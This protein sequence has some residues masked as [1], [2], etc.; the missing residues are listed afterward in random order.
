[1]PK[2]RERVF[3]TPDRRGAASA[4]AEGIA[5]QI[6]IAATHQGVPTLYEPDRSI[7]KVVGFPAVRGR[8]IRAEQGHGNRAIVRTILASVER[9]QGLDQA[10][11]PLRRQLAEVRTR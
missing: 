5:Q 7:A 11:A 1:M 3:D 6:E 4:A 10:V 9:A 8:A 2:T